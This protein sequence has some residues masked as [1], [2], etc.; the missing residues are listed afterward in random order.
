MKKLLTWQLSLLFWLATTSPL[1]AQDLEGSEDRGAIGGYADDDALRSELESIARDSD[2]ATLSSLATTQGNRKVWLLTLGQGDPHS[3]P[4]M[5]VVGNTF[6]PH[7]AGS[8][9]AWRLARRLV[10]RAA[11]DAQIRQFLTEQTIYVIPRPSPDA[12]MAFF[13]D[14]HYERGA[15]VRA[16]DDD[17][18]G[19]LNEDPPE[20]LNGD[21]LITS[22][23]VETPAGSYLPHPED[24]RVLIEAD[25]QQDE[26]GRWELYSEGVDNDG[27]RALN[28]DGAGGVVFNRNFTFEYP[29][30]ASG[31]GPHQISE[32]ETRA[33]ADF[34]FAHPN[35]Y[36][37]FAF[38]PHDNLMHPWKA[39]S[40][41]RIKKSL[42]PDDGPFATRMAESYQ[43]KMDRQGAPASPPAGGS[44]VHWA[45]FHF[46][47][48]SLGAR[49]WWIPE[50]SK[51]EQAEEEEE[52]ADA[53]AGPSSSDSSNQDASGDG[54]AEPDTRGAE[55]LRALAWFDEQAIDG[56]VDW[57]PVEHPDF[58]GKK[59]EVGG[60][61]PFMRM[62][63]PGKQLD[64]LAEQHAD[65]LLEVARLKAKL[66][67]VVDDVQA[68]GAGVF[69][70]RVTLTNQGYLPTVSAMGELSR[71]VPRLQMRIE[72][73]EQ[74]RLVSGVPR[75]AVPRLT[76]GGGRH[77]QEWLIALPKQA[78]ASKVRVVA[79]SSNVGSVE[80]TFDLSGEQ[81]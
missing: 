73:P 42:L 12:T 25:P 33:A 15:N 61:R 70:V 29:Y 2:L 68:L 44:F 50:V 69:R 60:F 16:T 51:E 14:P 43:Q 59:V 6:P 4:A 3:R 55:D 21:G 37:V 13:A 58:P 31:A 67:L 26:I 52:E 56:F 11:T 18:D 77:E 47:R 74:A 54:S 65:F 28:E 23:R 7:I 5:L 64:A 19:R 8:E 72:L 40:G 24:P 9:I 57:T 81:Q 1:D 71:V 45:Y 66:A 49:A 41:G 79:G 36:L 20:D 34:A 78:K 63:P 62:N 17:R 30:F 48:W 75:V 38:S 35:I 10:D 80:T 27:D 46:G 22:M 76:G 39:E 53:K 32:P